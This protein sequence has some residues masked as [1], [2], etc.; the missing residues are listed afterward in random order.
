MV[1]IEKPKEGRKLIEEKKPEVRK[2]LEVKKPEVGEVAGEEKVVS[3]MVEAA[4]TSP[5]LTE[6]LGSILISS[7]NKEKFKKS[8]V[9]E[10]LKDPELRKKIMLELIKKL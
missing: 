5:E 3:S 10:A 8:I 1:W 6:E 7:L 2:P 9:E 4:K